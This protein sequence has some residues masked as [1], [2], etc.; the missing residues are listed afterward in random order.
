MCN[1]INDGG[2]FHES[3]FMQNLT[4]SKL[5]SKK[6]IQKTTILLVSKMQHL[7]CCILVK[8]I[9]NDMPTQS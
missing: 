3:N 8:I 9:L 2:C 6:Y 5:H 1:Q 7:L 4:S